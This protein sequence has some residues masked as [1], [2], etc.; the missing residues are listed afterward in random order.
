MKNLRTDILDNIAKIRKSKGF[1]QDYLASKLG[2][3]Q[4]GYGLIENGERGLQYE[5]LLQIAIVF[6]MDVIDIITYPNKYIDS[7]SIL[8]DN[9]SIDEKVVLQIELKKEKK[10]QVMKLVFGENNLEILN[11]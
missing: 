8:K 3:K 10:E 9:F 1:S 7:N 5:V 2:M 6:E 4:A 11:K